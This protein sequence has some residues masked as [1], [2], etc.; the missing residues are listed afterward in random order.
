MEEIRLKSQQQKF[1]L[2]LLMAN[3]KV[4]QILKPQT[5]AVL[6]IGCTKHLSGMI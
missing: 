3:E 2:N 1:R 5:L 6:K 4:C